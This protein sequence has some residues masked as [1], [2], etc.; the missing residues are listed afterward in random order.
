MKESMA[1]KILL[2]TLGRCPACGNQARKQVIA[3]KDTAVYECSSCTLRYI[4]PCLS[5]ESMENAYESDETLTS[6]HSFHEGYYDYGSLAC[7]SKTSRDYKKALRLI[8][9]SRLDKKNLSIF[10]VG[11]GNGFFLAI[12]K[13]RGWRVAGIDSSPKNVELAKRKFNVDLICTNFAFYKKNEHK[14]DVISFWDVIEH[15]PDPNSA[16]QKAKEMLSPNGQ[17]LIGV[18]NDQSLLRRLSILIHRVTFGW[19]K[20]GLDKVYFLEHVAYFNLR[21]LTGLMRRH[22][23]ER[24]GYFYTSTD[25]NRFSF[26][27]SEKLIAHT[28]VTLGKLTGLQ[29]RLVAVFK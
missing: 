1:Q 27:V 2:T 7:E 18:P 9:A 3:I 25:L 24:T 16:I 19:V 14:F 4:D 10:D 23:L 22:G 26:K 12:A 5:L 21:S 17:L 29:N 20:K 11:A 13:E 15:L 6:L 8:E 28:V